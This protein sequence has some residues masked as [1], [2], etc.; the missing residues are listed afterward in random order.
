MAVLY[1]V[2]LLPD[3]AIAEPFLDWLRL[4]VA[5]MLTLPGFEGARIHSE[6]G[7]A[8]VYVVH[9]RLPDRAALQHYF[10]THAARMRA[11]GLARFPGQFQASRRI[12]LSLQ[13]GSNEAAK[14]P[15]Q[16]R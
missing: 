5:E 13:N 4:H 12:L 7:E 16:A 3:P 2:R 9:Y 1:E 11:D 8:T 15:H 6:E 14:P 10:D